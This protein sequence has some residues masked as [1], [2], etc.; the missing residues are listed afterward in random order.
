MIESARLEES[1]PPMPK[2]PFALQ[3]YSLNVSLPSEGLV[4]RRFQD[5]EEIIDEVTKE[6]YVLPKKFTN[7]F[8]NIRA[9]VYKAIL[10]SYALR[11]HTFYFLPTS[12]A[13][14]FLLVMETVKAQYAV[15]QDDINEYLASRQD[16]Y[17]KKVDT[18]ST[19]KRMLLFDKCPDLAERV[20]VDMFPLNIGGE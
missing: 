5:E 6:L 8:K 9:V 1:G 7:R 19:K 13:S 18:Y 4:Q 15:L 2:Q 20:I 12:K 11:I 3:G 16:D 14:E 17:I 10:P